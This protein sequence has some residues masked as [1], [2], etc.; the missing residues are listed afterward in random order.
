MSGVWIKSYD[1]V[2]GPTFSNL[3]S[4]SGAPH[5]RCRP[6]FD[7]CR[8]VPLPDRR[9]RP[10]VVK[11]KY[12]QACRHECEKSSGLR[13]QAQSD[14]WSTQTRRFALRTAVAKQSP[15]GPPFV[16]LMG[17]ETLV[18]AIIPLHEIV[19]V[20]CWVAKASQ[21]AGPDSAL[22]RAGEHFRESDAFQTKAKGARV[23]LTAIGNARV[24]AQ[25]VPRDFPVLV[26]RNN[27]KDTAHGL[28]RLAEPPGASD[29]RSSSGTH[30]LSGLLNQ[31]SS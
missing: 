13:V 7:V 28:V 3:H 6:I 27:G 22:Y 30:C 10:I 4:M 8:V 11:S 15:L 20:L 25:R 14:T 29:R 26:N 9:F 23:A 16:N 18:L 17:T 12:A 2:S 21:F 5:D 31:A 24:L 19:I 1:Y